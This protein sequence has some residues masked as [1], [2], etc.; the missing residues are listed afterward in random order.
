MAVAVVVGVAAAALVSLRGDDTS[1]GVTAGS[2]KANALVVEW[3]GA[4]VQ[5]E[6]PDDPRACLSGGE[7][8]P[9]AC[10]PVFMLEGFSFDDVESELAGGITTAYAVS[11][12]GRLVGDQMVVESASTSTAE[13]PPWSDNAVV[14]CPE[15]GSATESEL[16][17]AI[18]E[19]AA[20]GGL[21]AQHVDAID[22]G[23]WL[24]D[25]RV[26]LSSG[27][28]IYEVCGRLGVS[29]RIQGMARVLEGG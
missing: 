7:S 3:D 20:T 29:A 8:D 28:V 19:F 24:L 2:T 12:S 9:P 10:R 17:A 16:V 26:A 25:V 22:I 14:D 21:D 18:D 1:Q 6:G 5:Q 15:A 11:L 27:S 4:M 13:Y 23:N